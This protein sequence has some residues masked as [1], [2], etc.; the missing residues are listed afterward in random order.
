MFTIVPTEDTRQ[1]VRIRRFFLAVYG[2]AVWIAV[3]LASHMLGLYR[4]STPIIITH[5]ALMVLTAGVV[6]MLLRTGF[7]KRFQDPSL[8]VF[9]MVLAFVWVGVM[10]YYSLSPIRGS[11]IALY[12]VIFVFGIFRLSLRDFFVLV[13]VAA[14]TYAGAVMLLY[15]NHPEAVNPFLET[16]RIVLLLVALMWFSL[17]GAYIRKLRGKVVKTN[18]ELQNAMKRIEQLVIHDELTGVYN[19]RHLLDILEREKALADRSGVNFAVCLLD[20]DDF[21]KINDTYGHLA[22]DVVLREFAQAIKKDIRKEDY[23][24]RYGGEEFVVVFTGARCEENSTD[25]ALR[26]QSITR[27]LAFQEIDPAIRLTISIG[28]TIYR[29][30]EP[31]DDLL[32]RADTAMYRAKKSGKN[33]VEYI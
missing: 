29:F 33:R 15:H 32:T 18:T 2:Y 27:R 14:A 7:N 11:I 1:A 21:K 30:D 16:I 12:V 26:I 22:G 31:L 9:Q 10:V 5:C 17:I 28:I 23:V 19:R 25:C 24:A 4:S 20:L 13:A 3:L 8:T 6:Y